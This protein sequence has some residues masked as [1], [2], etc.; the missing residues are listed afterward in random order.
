MGLFSLFSR[1]E[2]PSVRFYTEEELS[3]F[4]RAMGIALPAEYRSFLLKDGIDF[5]MRW[6]LML[7]EEWCEP[8]DPEKLGA[9][10]LVRPFPHREAWNDGSL[11][12]KEAGWNS[13]YFNPS[14]ACGA[15]RIVNWGCGGYYLLVVSGP[16]TGTVWYDDRACGPRGILPLRSADGGRLSF[17]EFAKNGFEQ[18]K[19]WF[20]GR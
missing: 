14:L 1:K 11:F 3:D 7:L 8:Y 20:R 13:P 17:A 18:K 9:D 19:S 15:M 4:E 2:I 6:R 16:E 5:S 10:F 12:Q